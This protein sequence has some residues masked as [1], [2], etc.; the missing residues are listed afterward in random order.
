MIKVKLILDGPP[1]LSLTEEESI[2]LGYGIEFHS[3]L[4]FDSKRAQD[5]FG[6]HT[7][8]IIIE[9][10][11]G[12]FYDEKCMTKI[13]VYCRIVEETP[14]LCYQR[15]PQTDPVASTKS[16]RVRRNIVKMEETKNVV[17][18]LENTLS[19]TVKSFT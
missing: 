5:H 13:P 16:I 6:E 10:Y 1:C 12:V 17:T 11:S 9:S 15:F 19:K 18:N 8:F 4:V 2:P 3:L 14:E 7:A